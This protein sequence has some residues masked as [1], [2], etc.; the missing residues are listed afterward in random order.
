MN[1]KKHRGPFKVEHS[2]HISSGHGFF[3]RLLNLITNPFTYLLKGKIR[4]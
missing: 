2:I 1:K 4:Y 3:R